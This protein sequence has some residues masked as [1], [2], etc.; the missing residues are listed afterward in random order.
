[1]NSNSP[2]I[3]VSVSDVEDVDDSELVEQNEVMES[4]RATH[5]T[6]ATT[7]KENEY[8]QRSRP[9][10]TQNFDHLAKMISAHSQTYTGNIFESKFNFP[11]KWEHGHSTKG[12]I[13]QIIFPFTHNIIS[14]QNINLLE[15]KMK[16][17]FTLKE[18]IR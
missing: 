4:A 9:V 15:N 8:Y 10:H 12:H 11:G 3:K 6:S 17:Y 14:Y 13:P 1:M 5:T 18:I 16:M 7:E 2:S